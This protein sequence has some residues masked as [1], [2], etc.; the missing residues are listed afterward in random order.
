MVVC[1]YGP[2]CTVDHSTRRMRDIHYQLYLIRNVV[3]SLGTLIDQSTDIYM[4]FRIRR[5]I[6]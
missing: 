1:I 5:L 3:I 4:S 2:Y 6:L